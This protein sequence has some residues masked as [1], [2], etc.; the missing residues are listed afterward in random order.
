MLPHCRLPMD[1][2]HLDLRTYVEY[3]FVTAQK[4]I[5]NHLGIAN[6]FLILKEIDADFQFPSSLHC[7][8]GRHAV[9][10]RFTKCGGGREWKINPEN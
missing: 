9:N 3:N 10:A 4:R 7:V 5:Q 1:L 6:S 8:W 2:V